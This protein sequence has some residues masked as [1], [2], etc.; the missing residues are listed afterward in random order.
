M[1]LKYNV[2]TDRFDLK[3]LTINEMSAIAS[4]L[5]LASDYGKPH[6]KLSESLEASLDELERQAKS[7][8]IRS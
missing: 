1:L 7:G 4:A 3:G 5:N 8:I 2:N 6:K